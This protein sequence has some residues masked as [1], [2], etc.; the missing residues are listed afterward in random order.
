MTSL[1]FLCGDEALDAASRGL[2]DWGAG[3]EELTKFITWT[4]SIG[5]GTVQWA[6]WGYIIFLIFI[7]VSV[8]KYERCGLINWVVE[9]LFRA[10]P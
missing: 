10:L 4:I 1:R 3:D 8:L 2:L 7:T 9:S 6:L 5:Q